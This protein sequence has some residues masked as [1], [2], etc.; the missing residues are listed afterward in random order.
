MASIF[1]INVVVTVMSFTS[2]ILVTVIAAWTLIMK[3]EWLADKLGISDSGLA[4]HASVRPI[5]YA[6]IK[7]V[8]LYVI[9]QGI[10][11]FVQG[12]FYMRHS[13]PF[14]LFVWSTLVPPLLRVGIGLLLVMK[15]S[16]IFKT[17][18]EHTNNAE[19]R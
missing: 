18:D 13:P 9:I 12:L 11:V 14:G 8:G 19:P 15:T 3:A 5:L 4:P 6:G 10:P 17:L 2:V 7:L 1:G 16:F